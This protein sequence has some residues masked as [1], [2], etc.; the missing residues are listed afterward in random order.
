[1]RHLKY[2]D[3]KY[4]EFKIS[5]QSL[6][7]LHGL[8]K[9][10]SEHGPYV[11]AF[12]D[13]VKC[14]ISMGCRAGFV[15]LLMPGYKYPKDENRVCITLWMKYSN[16]DWGYIEIVMKDLRVRVVPIAPIKGYLPFLRKNYSLDLT[17]PLPMDV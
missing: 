5:H 4:P 6:Y 3:S 2:L 9:I 12:M 15:D 1:M 11:E 14:L 13:W 16:E 8:E 10:Y 7:H 17:C